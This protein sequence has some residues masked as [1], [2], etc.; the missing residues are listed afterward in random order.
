MKNLILII[1][2][3][4]TLIT[5]ENP[6][7]LK[8]NYVMDE[9]TATKIAEAIWLPIY[10]DKVL[11]KKPY[12]ARLKNNV[13]IVEGSLPEGHKGGVPYIEIRK[14]D[15]KILKVSHGK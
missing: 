3:F 1:I 4:T 8:R 13:W 7:K 11:M 2:S 9:V 10:G 6:N 12:H 14:T 5:I 15:C